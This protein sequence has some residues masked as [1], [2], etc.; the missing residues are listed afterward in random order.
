MAPGI[1]ARPLAYGTDLAGFR[2][3]SIN[4]AA[5]WLDHNEARIFHLTSSTFDEA[6]IHSSGGHTQLHRKAGA[7]GS[8]RAT[9]DQR[10]YHQVAEA[11]VSAD[12]VL[13]LGPATAKLE[14]IK[15]AHRHDPKLETKIVGVETVDHP[16]DGQIV[17]YARRYFKDLDATS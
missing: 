11:L 10:Y 4:H 1:A 2:R 8:H 6:T 3:K 13:V 5:V 14:L 7:D 15:H 9:E 17:A 16:T 12:D